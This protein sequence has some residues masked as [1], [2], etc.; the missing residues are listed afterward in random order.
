MLQLTLSTA[1]TPAELDGIAAPLLAGGVALLPTDTIYGLHALADDARGVEKVAALKGRDGDK[2][3]VVLGASADQLRSLGVLITPEVRA[4]VDE[5]WP[6]PLTAILPLEKPVAASRGSLS[7][8]VRIPDL[9]WLRLLLERTGPLL[10]TSA[11]RSGEVP[12]TTPPALAHDLHRALDLVVDG[13]VLDAKPSTIVDFS[14]TPR[15]LREG[16]LFFTQKVWKT[17]RKSL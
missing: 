14:G 15:V 13:G 2:P 9:P 5:L 6:G 11:N 12:I 8:A 1:P 10:S 17:L 16:E 4:V 3:F 7:L